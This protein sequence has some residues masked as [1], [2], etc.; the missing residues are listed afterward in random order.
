MLG[1]PKLRAL[2]Q[3]ITVSL[4]SLVPTG[5]FYRHLDAQL[6]LSFVREWVRDLYAE[7]GRPSIDPVVFFK[8][9]LIMFFEG[10]RSERRLIETASL[11]LAHRWYLGY[12]LDE[13]LPDHSSLTR[14]RKRLG[15]AIF[16]RFFEHVVELCQQVGLVWGKELFF[17][18]TK[19][20][21][22]AALNSMVPRFYLQAKEQAQEHLAALF[23]DEP[24]SVPAPV[25]VSRP[26][27]PKQGQAAAQQS[28]PP[29]RLPTA[30]SS[31]AEAE[32]AEA[33]QAVWKLLEHRRLDPAR[34]PGS[35]HQRLTDLRA[36]PTDPDAAL[37]N[38]GRRSALGYHDHYVVDG[39]KQRIILAALVTPADVMENTPMLDLLWRVRFRWH[40]HPN[41]AVG[42]T[43]Y[44]TVE[45]I[46]ALEDEG[47]RAYV[48]LANWD[49]TPFYGP[50]RFQYE[51]EQDQYR[52]PQ[53]HALR[54][55]TA[56]YT[57]GVTVYRA[58][59][60]TC[61]ACPVKAA[62]TASDHGRTIH[63]SF[64]AEYLERVH[65]YHERPSY[66]KAM[67]KRSVWVEPLF[68]EAKQWHG[69]RQF[70]LRGLENVNIEALLVAAGQNLKRW[71]AA[72]GWGR[73][74]GPQGSLLALPV[75]S[76][77][78]VFLRHRPMRARWEILGW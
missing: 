10:I 32:V 52:C 78:L 58:A 51:P 20:R 17:D 65:A 69:L 48:P 19:V 5:H 28:L 67:R 34:G 26:A 35:S 70:R 8:L 12:G 47:I 76:P 41:R 75:E 16:E 46:R 9:Q 43:T 71:L 37:M 44:G 49:R 40:L 24:E 14:I 60:A 33:N 68:G 30:L 23:A 57:E 15:L 4:E 54:R 18:A 50:S 25:V 77:I 6:D 66:Q 7:R 62:C 38:D 31:E 22:N 72:P 42:D 55:L 73:R 11:H 3:P 27:T 29:T 53:G 63:R 56:K 59:A 36:S 74:H 2:D 61:N 21:A 1:P 64:D 13:P 45:N 39:G